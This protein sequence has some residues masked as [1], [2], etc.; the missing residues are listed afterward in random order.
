MSKDKMNFDGEMNN[1]VEVQADNAKDNEAINTVSDIAE[2]NQV[3]ET[4][5]NE[6]RKIVSDDNITE[7]K[8]GKLKTLFKSR[9]LRKGG[10]SIAFTAVFIVLV[11]VVNMIANLVTTKVPALTFDLSASKTYELSQDTIDFVETIDKEVTVSILAPESK[12]IGA[13][14]DYLMASTLLNQYKNYNDKIKIKYVDIT[15]NPT[16]VNN[17]PEETLYQGNYIVECGDKYRVLTFDDLFETTTDTYGSTQVVGLQVEPA[18]TTAILNVTAENQIKV[19]FIDGFGDY[20]AG[21]LKKLLEQNNYDVSSVSTLTQ[22]IDESA[23]AVVLF[24]PSVD[25][26]DASVKKIKDF[27]NNNGNYGK[28]LI[29]VANPTEIESPNLEAL[30]EEWGMK[31]GEG[32]VAETDPSKLP[33]SQDY[34]TSILDYSNTEYTEGLKDSTLSLI[35]GE[36]VPVEITNENTATTLLQTST[37]AKLRLFSTA[38]DENFDFAN[39]EPQQYN[40]AAVGTKT[41]GDETSSNVIVFGSNLVFNSYAIKLPTYNNGSY[42]VNMFNKLTDNTDEGIT[43]DGKD[44]EE[45]SLG[46][47]T[48]QIN[49]WTI[50]CMGVIPVIIIIVAIV[51]WVRRRN[52]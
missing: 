32:V 24:T 48:D 25:L 22:E 12:Y 44:L 34:Y 20:D 23:E 27:L 46:I 47:T 35:G 9:K 26:D 39:V 42:I 17:Y 3:S 40:A 14:E 4:S 28:D 33:Y 5:E 19:Q 31:I 2:E 50:V 52:R 13:S 51:I 37:S 16:Y 15:A 30:L 45:P 8:E 10:L 7:K 21:A 43:I 38:N 11:I 29:Y 1:N 18:V 6:K 36:I 41:S 49:L